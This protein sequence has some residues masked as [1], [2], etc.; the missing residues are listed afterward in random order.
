[1]TPLANAPVTPH[2]LLGNHPGTEAL[3]A[4]RISS[5]LVAFEYADVKVINTQ[6]KALTFGPILSPAF[7]NQLCEM[8]RALSRVRLERLN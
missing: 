8:M 7:L 3:T 1:M 2:S 6:V 5:P 4:G